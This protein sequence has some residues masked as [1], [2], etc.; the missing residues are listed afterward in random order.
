MEILDAFPDVNILII[1][2]VMLDRYWWGSVSRISPEAPVPVVRMD[3]MTLTAGG[4]ANVAANVAGLGARATLVGVT[5]DDPEADVLPDVLR[6]VGV[7]D[8]HLV[9]AAGRHTTTKTRIV[10]HSQQIARV[11]QETTADLPDDIENAVVDRLRALLDATDAI[12]ISDYAKGF[13]TDPLLRHVIDH[14]KRAGIG[15][16]VDPKGRDYAKYRS[17]TML[18]PNRREAADACALEEDD[19]SVVDVAGERLVEDLELQSVLITQGDAGMTLFERGSPPVHLPTK[20][21]AVYDV[22]GAGDTVIASLAVAIAAG[23]STLLAAEIANTAAGL[24]VE[25]V[26]TTAVSVK[27]LRAAMVPE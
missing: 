12:I 15:V 19:Q 1:G 4:A 10:A 23:A 5:G 17:A 22:T 26:G 13:L 14:A 2:D 24:V 3:H 11:D 16:L 25:N 20:A 6:R 18:T 7:S 27:S 21:R 9:R 8:E